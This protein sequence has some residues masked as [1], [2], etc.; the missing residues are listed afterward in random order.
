M[1]WTPHQNM[2]VNAPSGYEKTGTTEGG[3]GRRSVRLRFVQ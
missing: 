3:A 1:G 2:A